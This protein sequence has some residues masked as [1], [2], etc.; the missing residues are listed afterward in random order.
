MQP[1]SPDPFAEMSV[2]MGFVLKQMYA[3]G[4]VC[5]CNNLLESAL[6]Y[7]PISVIVL[8]C[9]EPA[10]DVLVYEAAMNHKSAEIIEISGDGFDKAPSF[11]LV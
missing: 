2:E 4:R 9:I 5:R 7:Y 3:F 8:K 11:H 1:S 6:G 10:V